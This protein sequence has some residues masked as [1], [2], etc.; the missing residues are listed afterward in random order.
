MGGS[1]CSGVQGFPNADTSGWGAGAGTGMTTGAW[2]APFSGSGSGWGELL[3][4]SIAHNAPELG[5]LSRSE[6]LHT[7]PPLMGHCTNRNPVDGESGATFT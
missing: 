2:A 5:P 4:E 7:S 6:S 1:S 3:P